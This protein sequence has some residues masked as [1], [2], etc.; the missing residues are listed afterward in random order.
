MKSTLRMGAALLCASMILPCIASAQG[1]A[2]L[3][4]RRERVPETRITVD[5][6]EAMFTTMCALLAAG[7]GAD[8]SAENW[9]PMRAQLR[10]RLQHQQG[11]AVEVLRNFYRQHELADPGAMLSRY[12]WFG[13]VSGPAPDFKPT[14]R[15][16]ELPP[17][18]IALEGFQEIL[19][20]Y[21]KEQ[22][23][24]ELWRQ[25]QPIYNAEIEKLHDPIAD[26]TF[27]ATGYLREILEPTNPRTFTI[28]VEPLVG[29]ITN[30]RNFG[31]HYSLVLSGSE[32]LPT[33]VVRHAFLHFLLDS[34]PLMY[35]HVVAAK[36][37]VYD[38]AAKAP[39]LPAELKD[40][41]SSYFAE[42]LVR[43]VE[44]KL[45]RMS[46]GERESAMDI[47]DQAG[48]VFVRPLFTALAKFEQSEP[49]IRLYFPDLVRSVD[50]PTE[51]KRV[52]TIKYAEPVHVEASTAT[53]TEVVARRR[54]APTTI[55][56]DTEAIAALTEGERR[57]AEKNPRAAEASFQRVL[58]KYPDQPR[59]LYGLGMVAVLERDGE[60]A[61]QVFGRLTAGDH[62][63]TNDPMVLAWSHVYL[64]RILDSEG[65]LDRAKAEYQAALAVDG[66]P[67]PARQAATKGL[68]SLDTAKPA[69]RP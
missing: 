26:I 21:Y 32:A 64:A 59:A 8:V 13:L 3:P 15:R 50:T 19:A 56:N 57:I 60:R 1:A 23:I 44:L 4:I 48:L 45:K 65:Q 9:S 16:D 20:A 28:V 40:D 22:K 49:G 10:D 25:V 14:L 7:F 51:L 17:E 58:A 47:D 67:E 18:V 39:R 38:I 41:F 11:A 55:P 54:A 29:R 33:D 53:E 42:C 34:L 36:R 62:A 35:P 43:A 66:G 37:P 46:P 5:G 63:A 61:K 24:G 2:Q 27:I 12:I 30:V 6:S 69:E 52:A 68:A 31:D